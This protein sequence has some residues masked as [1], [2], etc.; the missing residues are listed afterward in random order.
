MTPNELNEK[1][2]ERASLLNKAKAVLS[3]SEAAN[4]AP[5]AE[6]D[7][8]INGWVADAEKISATIATEEA[9]IE[10]RQNVARRTA[11]IDDCSAA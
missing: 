5:S 6:E 10:A 4:R 9:A 8:A 2:A 3:I 7:K 11:K 1:K